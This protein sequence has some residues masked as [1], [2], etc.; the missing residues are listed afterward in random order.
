MAA[1]FPVAM[2]VR[3]LRGLG[4]WIDP[5]FLLIPALFVVLPATLGAYAGSWLARWRAARR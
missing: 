4:L 2:A 5:E 3:V 1:W